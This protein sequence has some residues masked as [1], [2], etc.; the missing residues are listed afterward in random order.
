M[1]NGDLV[2]VN[3]CRVMPY[4]TRVP[5]K[6]GDKE[7]EDLE[8]DSEEKEEK[9]SEEDLESDSEEKEGVQLGYFKLAT[10][11]FI[12]AIGM[13]SSCLA[14]LYEL[15]CHQL[16]KHSTEQHQQEHSDLYTVQT[17]NFN[18]KNVKILK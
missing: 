8:D 12:L 6:N 16:Q 4:E 15:C 5:E 3:L 18:A 9:E 14:F 17:I 1:Q 7:N 13:S 2:K 10:L 11:F